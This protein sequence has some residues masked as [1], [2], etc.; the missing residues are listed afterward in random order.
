MEPIFGI[1]FFMTIGI[2]LW[3]QPLYRKF[4]FEKEPCGVSLKPNPFERGC[5]PG[6]KNMTEKH[7]IRLTETVKGSG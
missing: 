1:L 6:E 5:K 4:Q 3:L 7:E 2:S